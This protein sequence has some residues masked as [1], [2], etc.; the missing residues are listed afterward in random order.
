MNLN[1]LHDNPG[2]QVH[3]RRARFAQDWA[4]SAAGGKGQRR[5]GKSIHGFEGG[6]T[7]LH[8]RL[9]KRGFK[10][11][12]GRDFAI[13]NLG[14]IQA[15]IDAGLLKGKQ[16]L[17]GADLHEAGLVGASRDGVRL[18]AKGGLKAKVNFEVAGASSSA[19]EAVKKAG[20]SVTTTYK[21]TVH[22]NKKGEAGKRLQR[23]QKAG[24]SGGWLAWL[25]LF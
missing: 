8:R 25:F 5:V 19:V 13:V 11:L 6:Q 18:L 4:S 23:R 22:L 1:Q 24:K 14:R 17:T 16:T 9:P 12:F 15:A 2:A 3:R 10:S 20:G 21:K 7:P